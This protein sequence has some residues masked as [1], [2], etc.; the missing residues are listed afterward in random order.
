MTQIETSN[1]TS[2]SALKT[3]YEA[4]KD[5]AN[6]IAEALQAAVPL[7]GRPQSA[8]EAFM[9]TYSDFTLL[10]HLFKTAQETIN[11]INLSQASP[12]Q[13]EKADEIF[14]EL[15][16]LAKEL[17]ESVVEQF[18]ISENFVMPSVFKD[19]VRQ[20]DLIEFIVTRAEAGVAVLTA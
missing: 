5:R 13:L 3:K 15:A 18:G 11:G 9:L 12:D 10:Q 7:T 16:D 14:T 4:L 17:I 8:Q 20:V 6:K 19:L 1:I 2:G